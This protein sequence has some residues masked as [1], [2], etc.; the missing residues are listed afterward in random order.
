MEYQGEQI[1]VGV[2]KTGKPEHVF[3]ISEH[4]MVLASIGM[5]LAENFLRSEA[6]NSFEAEVYSAPIA[7]SVLIGNIHLLNSLANLSDS[8]SDSQLGRVRAY[9]SS[10]IDAFKAAYG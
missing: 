2:G 10:G 1:R 4:E 7:R 8:G 9:V 3:S 6:D 5:E